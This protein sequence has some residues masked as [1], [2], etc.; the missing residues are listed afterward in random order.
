VYQG[1]QDT[2]VT[3][4]MGEY[5]S[6]QIPNAELRLLSEKGHLW[7]FMNDCELWKEMI[8]EIVWDLTSQGK[9][10]TKQK[11]TK[12]KSMKKEENNETQRKKKSKKSTTKEEIE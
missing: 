2:G 5:L 9:T 11:S 10:N 3:K 4:A 1:E 6:K 7:M 8:N 12:T